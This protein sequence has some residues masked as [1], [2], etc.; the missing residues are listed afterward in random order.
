MAKK[1]KPILPNQRLK[2]QR[3]ER[4]WSQLYV[5]Q[6]IGTNAFTIGR[7]ERGKST[8]SAY[9]RVKLRDLFKLDDNTL[10][11]VGEA[12]SAR[13][14]HLSTIHE[15]TSHHSLPTLYD[16]AIPPLPVQI[17]ELVG[18]N[19][20]LRQL[21][22][23]LMTHHALAL[24][25]LNGLP[26]VGKTALANQLAHDSDI[27]THFQHGILWA[28]VGQQ[29]NM[30]S[31]LSAWGALLNIAP[32]EI[33][34][35]TNTA[36][37]ASTLRD[38]IG[39]RRMLIVLDDVWRIE[40]ALTLKIGGP[41]CTYLLTTRFPQ[42]AVQFAAEDATVVHEL[43]EDD[44]L[45][46]LARF[47]PAVVAHN[48]DIAR[49]LV[50]AVGGLPLALT[51]MGRYLHLHA[52]SNQPRRIQSALT[53][54]Q[55]MK[56]RLLLT[57]PSNPATRSPSLPTGTSFSLQAVI[58]LSDQQLSPEAQQALRALAIFAPKPNTFS[59][60]V[61]LIVSNVPTH[62]LDDLENAG[63]LELD[64][65]GRYSLHQT[66]TD[67][68]RLD[69]PDSQ[70]EQ[71]FVQYTVSF[72]Q[73]YSKEYVRLER[74]TV[75]LLT[76]LHLA[77]KHEMYEPLTQIVL[78]MAPFWDARGQYDLAETY[79]QHALVGT[80]S[81]RPFPP[82]TNNGGMKNGSIN[83]DITIGNENTRKRSLQEHGESRSLQE[84]RDTTKARLHLA[85]GRVA[86]RRGTLEAAEEHYEAGFV[87][88]SQQ[89]NQELM[90][91]LLANRG[92]TAINAGNFEVAIKFAEEGLTLARALGDEWR[93]TAL[94]KILG[95]AVDCFGE[96]Q[97]GDRLYLEGL[98][99]ARS[100]GDWETM[101]T[102]LQNLGAKAIK[103]GD[104]TLALV[105]VQEGL[106]KAREMEHR[107]RLSALLMLMG[108]IAI[109]HEGY[110]QARIYYQESL[111]IARSIGHR[112]R[113]G[114][115]LQNLGMLEGSLKHYALANTY[116]QES[117]EI[118]RAVG[119]K[120]LISETLNEWGEACIG[121]GDWSQA[122][123]FFSEALPLAQTIRTQELIAHAFFGMGRIDAHEEH[124]E[125]ARRKGQ[126]ALTIFGA[127]RHERMHDVLQWLSKLPE[128]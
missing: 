100:I 1:S 46:L 29:P 34:T 52:H 10:G 12:N 104:Y 55:S 112:V 103:R 102:L 62:V 120:W 15:D 56:E 101:C 6:H 44:G 30:T 57:H 127:E 99:L 4:G 18:R 85:L 26:G 50:Q 39:A 90:S 17:H 64:S 73:R 109:R 124:Y 76:A 43:N 65:T 128:A 21:K 78:A 53:H 42:L 14:L 63:L 48:Q 38:I 98:A 80:A 72:T 111:D 66:I 87:L 110:E 32:S 25:A 96:F 22:E 20:L 9:F 5:A 16:P 106:A 71:R 92:E 94:L 113:L 118:A 83:A 61:A 23:H 24:S 40:D 122:K 54:I 47:A 11:F 74:G 67:Y 58:A 51:I 114:N 36:T 119:H 117:L 70:A 81:S 59:E 41:H 93:I 27:L 3:A 19:D 84:H 105:Y 79:L 95:E 69:T 107:Q 126:Q 28:G 49:T 33:A 75:N 125:E 97:R 77:T 2:Q 82:S 108:V 116:F 37:W 88:A 123:K 60:E 68:A 8:P 115:V 35:L 7:W 31:L 45:L 89:N 91:S 13:P 121:H 86:E